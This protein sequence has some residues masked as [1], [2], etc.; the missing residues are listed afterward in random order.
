MDF[1]DGHASGV[2]QQNLVVKVRPAGLVRG[3]SSSL[4]A[5]NSG[6][7]S[8]CSRSAARE[9]KQRKC[10]NSTKRLLYHKAVIG[11]LTSEPPHGDRPLDLRTCPAN[12]HQG[13]YKE[14]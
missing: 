13:T 5:R 3:N 1:S 10:R 7:G 11:S 12:L 2:Q 6:E 8:M 14:Q 4:M 9:K